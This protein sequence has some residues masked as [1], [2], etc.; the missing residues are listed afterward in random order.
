LIEIKKDRLSFDS[1]S[2][3]MRNLPLESLAGIVFHPPSLQQDR[4]R[5]L[6]RL[7]QT[8]GDSDRLLLDNGDELSGLVAGISSDAVQITADAKPVDIKTNRV[9]ALIFNPALRRKSNPDGQPQAWIGLGDGS[10]LLATKLLVE[11]DA[12]SFTAAGE[13]WKTLPKHLVFLQPLQGR[14]V[15]LSAL[16]P[17]EYRQTPFLG[18][19]LT[20]RVNDKGTV[21]LNALSALSWP[22]QTDRNAAGG[23]LRCGGRLFL[24]GLGVHSAARIAYSIDPSYRQFKTELGIDDSTAGQGSV[25]FRILVDGQEKF[26]GKTVRGGDVPTPVSIDVQGA[27]KLEL[28]VDYADRADVLDHADWLDARFEK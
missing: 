23:L 7:L 18:D 11:G 4:D 9:M 10:R 8:S 24:K 12:M 19:V 17:V 22:L 20:Q 1:S 13:T 15:Y 27:K 25:Q 21:P 28:I 6:D 2:L 14:A 5:L 26:A 3:G 16:K